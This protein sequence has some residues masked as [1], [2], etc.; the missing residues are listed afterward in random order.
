LLLNYRFFH[1][2]RLAFLFYMVILLYMK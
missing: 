2:G 1:F